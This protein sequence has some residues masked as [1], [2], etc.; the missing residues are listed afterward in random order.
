MTLPVFDR[1]IK[2]YILI[3]ASIFAASFLVGTFAPV[4]LQKEAVE[5]FKFIADAFQGLSGGRLFFYILSHNLMASI[6]ILFS[7]M[8]FGV[9]PVL[10]IGANGFLLGVLYHQVAETLGYSKAAWMVLPHVYSRFQP[11]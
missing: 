4:P 9:I 7:G 10:A 6:L 8:L 3:L 2:P 5:A 1:T 11:F